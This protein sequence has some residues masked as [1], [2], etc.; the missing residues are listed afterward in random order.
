MGRL[1]RITNVLQ[2]ALLLERKEYQLQEQ[3]RWQ[4][5]QSKDYVSS[6]QPK[7]THRIDRQ[8]RKVS[9]KH[10]SSHRVNKPRRKRRSTKKSEP[11]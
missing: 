3:A 11:G 2:A 7:Q 10:M 5:E 6:E 8:T 1:E 9:K 4:Q